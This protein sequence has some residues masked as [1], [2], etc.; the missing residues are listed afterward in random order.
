MGVVIAA[1]RIAG[2]VARWRRIVTWR[3]VIHAGGRAAVITRAIIMMVVII[4]TVITSVIAPVVAAVIS[5]VI[6][7]V[8]APVMATI[9]I[10]A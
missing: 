6:A 5:A 1:Y 4:M 8:A 7:T 9:I 10:V 3:D 2:Y